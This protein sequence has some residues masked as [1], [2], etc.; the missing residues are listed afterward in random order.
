MWT[1]I[2]ILTQALQVLGKDGG[3][4]VV[5]P[6]VLLR[7]DMGCRSLVGSGVSLTLHLHCDFT[8]SFLHSIERAR[9]SRVPER[10]GVIFS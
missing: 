2:Y 1:S 8:S 5:A 4:A 6:E 3:E 10:R 7:K 9:H